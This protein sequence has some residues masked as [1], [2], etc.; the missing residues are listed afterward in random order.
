MSPDSLNLLMI[1]CTVD[2]EVFKVFAIWCWGTLFWVGSQLIDAV[3]VNLFP[4]LLR[5]NSTRHQNIFIATLLLTCCQLN[6][7]VEKCSFFLLP[8]SSQPLFHP[9]LLRRVAVIKFKMSQYFNEIMNVSE[10]E[11]LIWDHCRSLNFTFVSF[12][13]PNCLAVRIM[14]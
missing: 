4:S 1:L 8:L 10:F 6:E 12:I 14:W 9:T 11:H 2:D 5:R 13:F 7:L 3:L